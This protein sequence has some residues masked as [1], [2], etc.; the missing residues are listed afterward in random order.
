MSQMVSSF[1]FDLKGPGRTYFI[2]AFIVALL[3]VAFYYLL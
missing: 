3:S 1:A 2:L